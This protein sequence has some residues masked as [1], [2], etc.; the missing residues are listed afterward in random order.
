[1][2]T[3]HQ[4]QQ[5][6][7]GSLSRALSSNTARGSLYTPHPMHEH[8]KSHQV[9]YEKIIENLTSKYSF[10]LY[11]RHVSLLQ[12]VARRTV[13]GVPLKDMHY[14]QR[15]IDVCSERLKGVNLCYVPVLRDLIKNCS[16]PFI[17]SVGFS[18]CRMTDNIGGLMRSVGNCMITIS[19]IIDDNTN[20]TGGNKTEANVHL[21]ELLI[22]C[23]KTLCQF[24]QGMT[25]VRAK[26]DDDVDD[27]TETFAKQGNSHPNSGRNAFAAFAKRTE[28][29][30]TSN[31]EGNANNHDTHRPDVEQYHLPEREWMHSQ[32]SSN[33]VSKKLFQKY[34]VKLEVTLSQKEFNGK[35]AADFNIVSMVMEAAMNLNYTQVTK[36]CIWSLLTTMKHFSETEQNCWVLTGEM[37]AELVVKFA[38][39]GTYTD[40]LGSKNN[41]ENKSPKKSSNEDKKVEDGDDQSGNDDDPRPE[42]STTLDEDS[43]RALPTQ[44]FSPKIFMIILDILWNMLEF[45]KYFSERKNGKKVYVDPGDAKA[46]ILYEVKHPVKYIPPS[47]KDVLQTKA[48][49]SKQEHDSILDN[50]VNREVLL[51]LKETFIHLHSFERNQFHKALRNEILIIVTILVQRDVLEQNLFVE[52]EFLHAILLYCTHMEQGIKHGL[53]KDIAN[54]DDPLDFELKILMLDIISILAA[55]DNLPKYALHSVHCNERIV[56]QTATNVLLNHDFLSFLF[57][58]IDVKKQARINIGQNMWATPLELFDIKLKVLEV[59]EKVLPQCPSQHKG[60][61][62]NTRLLDFLEDCIYGEGLEGKVKL[63]EQCLKVL[64]AVCSKGDKNI[65]EDLGDDGAIGLLLQ[66]LVSHRLG[67]WE[68]VEEPSLDKEEFECDCH[69]PAVSSSTGSTTFGDCNMGKMCSFYKDRTEVNMR[70]LTLLILSKLCKSDVGNKDI[71]GRDNG[72]EIVIP[73]LQYDPVLF[74]NQ[75]LHTSLILSAID[76]VW[77][78]VVGN[79]INSEKFCL[80]GGI[81]VLADLLD[82][83]PTTMFACKSSAMGLLLD[84]LDFEPALSHLRMW[85]SAKDVNRKIGNLLTDLWESENDRVG[86]KKDENDCIQD[87]ANPLV[88]SEQKFLPL[89]HESDLRAIHKNFDDDV[90][91]SPGINNSITYYSVPSKFPS[92]AVLEVDENMRAKVY[93]IF[94]K[95]GFEDHNL[96]LKQQMSLIVIEQ[97][98]D[99]KVGEVWHEI[100][101]ELTEENIIPVEWDMEC[102]REAKQANHRKAITVSRKQA[103]AKKDDLSAEL[104]KEADMFTLIKKHHLMEE[105]AQESFEN[106]VKRTSRI[107]ELRAYRAEKVNL[108]QSSRVPIAIPGYEYERIDRDTQFSEEEGVPVLEHNH[109]E[110]MTA[111]NLFTYRG[112]KISLDH[113]FMK[114][115]SEVRRIVPSV[116]SGRSSRLTT[117][118]EAERGSRNASAVSQRSVQVVEEA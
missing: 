5:S 13:Q 112:G 6:L 61:M 16:L 14:F 55:G 107:D 10:D 99:F 116:S 38:Y 57:L 108:I 82:K 70:A 117:V 36:E 106:Y 33:L 15:I 114:L 102:I 87:L 31:G 24:I 110:D 18:Q 35:I 97:Y 90:A 118:S 52:T 54:V 103:T 111:I 49:A 26:P 65:I 113:K 109:V 71:F 32:A 23:S 92:R 11:D 93:A 78:T 51:S 88:G 83:M 66:Y 37:M 17:E 43:S 73:Y 44:E 29:S 40:K 56:H 67:H 77:N 63:M 72:I 96:N 85:T 69:N 22:T 45:D 34:V 94:T 64:L 21:H 81:Y 9:N 1:M 28:A 62:G 42:T 105:K 48:A 39:H 68:S 100:S 50:I 60:N 115:E 27:Y 46:K 91:I 47:E 53:V 76:C 12:R 8:I 79:E 104:V 7:G 4:E 101:S 25:Y 80:G 89:D 75:C 98:L 30:G 19:E 3:P 20:S 59:M 95:I 41:G 74:N 84:L 58:Y 2:S 86:F